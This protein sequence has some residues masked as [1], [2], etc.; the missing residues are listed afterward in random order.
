MK[1]FQNSVH[2]YHS[3]SFSEYS[4][5][6]EEIDQKF[7]N[8]QFSYKGTFDD[9]N[10]SYINEYIE[11]AVQASEGSRTD[12]FRV[13]V[14]LAQNIAQNSID[15][16]I[17]KRE[18]IGVG[19]M[20]IIENDDNFEIISGNPA[21]NEDARIISEKCDKIN[22]ST[23]D[24]LRELKREFRRMTQGEMGNANIGLIKIALIS[25]YEFKYFITKI[26]DSVSFFTIQIKI[27]K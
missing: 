20:L 4:D 2:K 23:P 16:E 1:I 10:L 18:E 15:R 5:F 11:T 13:F 26:N 25:G 24:E 14:E 3:L 17:V 21:N 9:V 27:K 22:Q 19:I 12:L 6:Y 8:V 7:I